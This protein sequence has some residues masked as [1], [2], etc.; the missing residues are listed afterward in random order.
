MRKAVLLMLLLI[1]APLLPFASANF[2]PYV[3]PYR[4]IVTPNADG[5]MVNLTENSFEVPANA[6]ILDAWVNVST[7]A[8]GDGGVGQYWV[9]DDPTSNF[10][11]GT[12]NHS[13]LEVF[14]HNVTLEVNQSIGR[15]DDFETLSLRFQQ[16]SPGGSANVWRMAE[17]SQF[18]GP[19]GM[20]YS[21]R[22]AGG[23]FI[24]SL[25]SDGSLIAATLPE[26]PL[27]AGTHAWLTSN[28]VPIPSLANEWRISFN[29]WYHLHAVNSSTGSSGA[30]LEVSLDGGSTWSW[31]EPLGGYTWNISNSAPV[32]S[33]APGTGFGVFG[34]NNASGW[35]NSTFDIS[36]LNTTNAT[37]MQHRFVVWTDPT[38]Q[39]DRPGWYVDEVTVSNLGDIP[40][41]W[42]HGSLIGEYAAD[43]HA[44]LTIPA[45][46][47]V[48]SGINGAWM[49]RYWS[50]FDLEGGHWDNYEVRI[51]ADNLSW[52]RISPIGGIPGPN[53]LTLGSRTIMQ[54]S[55]GWVEI[56]HPFPSTFPIPANGSIFVRFE[57]ETDQLPSS[58]YGG[59]LDAPEGVF[60]DDLQI[61][62]TVNGQTHTRW[63]E[64]FTTSANGY[65]NRMGG[66]SF[67]QWQHLSTWGNNGPSE[68]TWSF[69]DA[70]QVADGWNV[71]TDF[72]QSWTFGATSNTN[73]WGPSAWPSGSTGAAMGLTDRHQATTWTHLVSPTYHVPIGASSRIVFDH[74][75]C[76]E[77][78]W[79]GGALY[80]SV[81]NGT[82]WQHFGASIPDFYDQPHYNNFQSP[83]Y[84]Q[85]AWDG[86]TKKG[87]CQSNKT[88]E[89]MQADISGFGGQ[90][91][92]FRFSFFSDTFI[93]L[94]GW[95]L[96]NIGIVVDWFETEGTWTSP[97]IGNEYRFAPTLDIDASIPEG[98]WVKA[99]ILDANGT[100]LQGSWLTQPNASF[101]VLF[102]ADSY[103]LQLRFG[104]SN[105][106][107]TP[108][109]HGLYLGAVRIFNSAD[110]SN[111]WDISSSLT[112]DSLAG[113]ITNPTLQI[114]RIEGSAAY[115]DTPI[116]AVSIVADAAGS[117]FEIRDGQGVLI[118][119]GSLI[120]QTIQLPYATAIIRPS[121]ILQQSGWIHHASFTGHLGTP[122][123]SGT[124]DVGGDGIIDW[125]W[126]FEPYGALGWYDGPHPDSTQQWAPPQQVTMLDQGMVLSATDDITWTWANGIHDSMLAGEHRILE[127]PWTSILNQSEP[128]D[129]VFIPLAISWQS[130]YSITGLG[131]ALR[132][133]Q[134][135]AL[136]GTG[137]AQMNSGLLHIPII[138]SA[139]QGGI[140]VSGG[141]T[142][143]QRIV[144]EVVSVPSGTMIPE[145]NV[146][147]VTE[148]THLLDSAL[149]DAVDLRME[150]SN[151]EHLEMRVDDIWD[152][153]HF[154][155]FSGST[156][157]VL[158]DINIEFLNSNTIRV[159][160]NLQTQWTFDDQSWIRVLAEAAEADGFT[161]GPGHG[162]IG[163]SNHQA[164][165]NDI[166]VVSWEVRDSSNRLLS[167]TWDSRY[168]FFTTAGSTIDINGVVR[169]EGIANTHPNQDSYTI[170]L[171]IAGVNQTAQVIGMN[172]PGGSWSTS[173]D[174]PLEAGNFTISPW[175]VSIGP[176][177]TSVFGAE[178]ASAGTLSVDLQVDT[179]APTLGPLMIHT[180]NGGRPADANIVSPNQMLPFWIEVSDSEL[181]SNMISLRYWLESLHD[182]DQDGIP[183]ESEYAS[184][185]QFIGSSMSGTVRVNFP[186]ISLYELSEGDK[187]SC[188]IEGSDYAGFEF[189]DAGQPGFDSDLATILVESQA[190][191]QVSLNS[192]SLNRHIEM[193]LLQGISHTFSFIITDGNG[194]S[195]IDSIDLHLSGD[196]QGALHFDPLTEELS[197]P[198]SSHV[199]PLGVRIDDLGNNAYAID[200]DFAIDLHAPDA[201]Q[202]GSWVPDLL[203]REDNEIVSHNTLD[204]TS[205]SWALDHRLM[206]AVDE[207]FDLTAPAMPM[208]NQ[209]LSLQPGDSMSF[210]ASIVHREN[211]EPL[212]IDVEAAIAEIEILEGMQMVTQS[213]PISG[214]GFSTEILL[215]EE[216]WPGPTASIQFNLQDSHLF[217]TS[218]SSHTFEVA[219]DNVAPQ[220]EFQSS[221][222]VYLQSDRLSNQLVSFSIEDAGGMGNQSVD[223]HWTYRRYGVDIVDAQ[224]TYTMEVGAYSGEQWTYSEYIDFTPDVTL[225][226][227]DNLVVWIEGQDL[228]GNEIAGLGTIS[229]PRLPSLDVMHFS[230][231]L[232]SVWVEPTK[233]EVGEMVNVDVRI[234]NH[235]NLD[236]SVD[237]GL[238][239]WE[240][241]SSGGEMLLR[242]GDYNQSLTPNESV[243]LN[244]QFEAWRE[245][246]L[247]IYLVLNEDE[248]NR[249]SVDIPP[250][251]EQGSGDS[252][253]SKIFADTPFIIGL[254]MILWCAVGFAAA[255]IW[256]RR[257]ERDEDEWF[258]SEG[259]EYEDEDWPEPPN[260]FPD[261]NPPP[262]PQDLL[263]DSTE[264][265]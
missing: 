256:S 149:F 43:A 125:S 189:I 84:G 130:T 207:A 170:A 78:G 70:P 48:N 97:L 54:D 34:G 13:S 223:V 176:S 2:S 111:G 51:S 4:M 219:I 55:A 147:I 184:S 109:I 30:W 91:I 101:P 188:Y 142:H 20:N 133:I 12:L 230:P 31:V 83:F 150:T 222:L 82:S 128:S 112:Q 247:R 19:F 221:S 248:N 165:E 25:A 17:P 36:H 224:G 44:Y 191:T 68:S 158:H 152:T 119:S 41:S 226:S 66:G 94:D 90:D 194:L 64:N 217:N 86:S 26:D 21:A 241:Q 16:Y 77:S 121:I 175:I 162:M 211:W 135:D 220:I 76:T 236:G 209:R 159:E 1:T 242:L 113:N 235:G 93:E 245:G 251:R 193:S 172:H 180:P 60:I 115:G 183:D 71:Y 106:E 263:D 69:E 75:I 45:Q 124:L 227:G 50:D 231:V 258:E 155:Q 11:Q 240:S 167:N 228:A 171:E 161:L 92:V 29:H 243:I 33:G 131:P 42:F 38:G 81:D 203:I 198:E 95:Y 174:L 225:E 200:F 160:W 192:I 46:I 151:G 123:N 27:P 28:P 185:S 265:E 22:Q 6:T 237:V 10:S 244:Y 199:V 254:G 102:G 166:E 205:L 214:N 197:A 129:F 238:W 80:T 67:D 3:G 210:S 156:E 120:N 195:S 117:L 37:S 122:M 62:Q 63:S 137:P 74:F 52:H 233:P 216:I 262:M 47:N 79:D 249:Q 154:S 73:G 246:D 163:G 257:S 208:F 153:A 89:N 206:W 260:Q 234:T 100:T 132:E 24:P 53:G 169:F 8:N 255:T 177:G 252:A 164:M 108:R 204:L 49:L 56:A 32:P 261:E 87:T 250:I 232:V 264:E 213:I 105:H 157:M 145:Q 5:T 14:E 114:Q 190:P 136:N 127:Y 148:H 104:T 134:S 107:L 98:T 168:P 181:L 59:L 146:T 88:F 118:A 65:H 15:T 85:W 196:E 138:L 35:V 229:S 141:V 140:Q 39:V 126:N 103:R 218:I 215:N 116:E 201:W 239:A 23:G 187:I 57:V 259:E 178:D 253:V 144:N 9:A 143:A 96:D 139:D 182:L 212:D 7:D 58:G 18:N 179:N 99:S 40:G 202:Q 61:T 72:G 110:G 186:A 173:I